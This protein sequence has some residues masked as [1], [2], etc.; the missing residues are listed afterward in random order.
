[1]RPLEIEP[2]RAKSLSAEKLEPFWDDSSWVAEEKIDGWRELMHI[3][4]DLPRMFLT[5]RRTSSRTGLLS[6][7]GECVPQLT[8]DFPSYWGYTVLDG[9][10]VAPTGFRDIAGIMNVS[11][12][13]AAARIAEIG[14]P[15]YRIFDILFCNG[16]DLREH[17]LI[18]RR[19]ELS[20]LTFGNDLIKVVPQH[21][22]NK[23]GVYESIVDAGGEGVILKDLFAPYGDKSAWVKVKKYSTLDV[24]VTGFTDARFGRT[25]KYEGQIGAVVV[26]VWCAGS[27]V[28]VGQ[29]SG[30]DDAT[31][32]EMTRDQHAWIG[33]VIEVAAQ[34]FGKER[35]RHPR[36]KRK[37]PD[38]SPAGCTY[39]K[40]MRDL[41]AEAPNRVVTGEQQELFK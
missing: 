22:V 35:L 30:M 6:E 19:A 28:E 3:G 37:R 39:E 12:A 17:S 2:A 33:T 21:P 9:E 41:S 11:P 5:G 26:A 7:K 4:G 38:A 23:R 15:I 8:P 10:V 1:V 29:V 31:R 13:D 25:G 14:P 34:E 18:E 36:Y 20:S 32:L 24:V 16:V 27:L 40:M